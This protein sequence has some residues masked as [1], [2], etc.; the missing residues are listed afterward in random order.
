MC[1]TFLHILHTAELNVLPCQCF[2]PRRACMHH[3]DHTGRHRMLSTHGA[4][5]HHHHHHLYTSSSGRPVGCMSTLLKQ[6]FNCAPRAIPG[7]AGLLM[8]APC[9]GVP[10]RLLLMSHSVTQA[11][12]SANCTRRSRSSNWNS[13]LYLRV[14]CM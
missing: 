14:L 5:H 12:S 11:S 9:A 6:Q 4:I 2:P 8:P 1:G 10:Q 3:T 7:A 13:A